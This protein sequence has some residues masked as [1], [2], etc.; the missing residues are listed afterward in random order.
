MKGVVSCCEYLVCKGMWGVTLP[1]FNFILE[2]QHL[3]LLT[4][5]SRKG[6]DCGICFDTKSEVLLSKLVLV[7]NILSIMLSNTDQRGE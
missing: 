2:D 1:N 6:L 3:K 4:S 7:I 5:F